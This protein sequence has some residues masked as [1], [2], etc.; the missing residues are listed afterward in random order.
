MLLLLI[1]LLLAK[2]TGKAVKYGPFHSAG[3]VPYL[4]FGRQRKVA[5]RSVAI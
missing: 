4:D 3:K 5:V 1:R 2:V